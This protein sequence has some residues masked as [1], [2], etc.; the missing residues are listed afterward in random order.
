M[1]ASLGLIC[2]LTA[3]AGCAVLPVP[4]QVPAAQAAWPTLLPID[5]ILAGVPPLPAADPAASVTARAAAL[6]ARAAALAQDDPPG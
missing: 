5:Q 6:K 4:R 3:P 2:L 1:R